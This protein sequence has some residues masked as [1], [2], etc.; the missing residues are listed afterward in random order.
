MNVTPLRPIP[1]N[2][3]PALRAAL[4]QMRENLETGDGVRGEPLRRRITLG[5][6]VSLGMVDVVGR[7]VGT[8]LTGPLDP[9]AIVPSG[10][11]KPNLAT[12]P[13][14]ENLVATAGFSKILLE[15]DEPAYSN[16]GLTEVYRA[17]TD[18]LSD[19]VPLGTS[20]FTLYADSVE[21]GETWFYW[22]RFV[23][24]TDVAGPYNDDAG[25]EATTAADPAA[26]LAAL[27]GVI[28]AS[29]LH[30]DLTS[31]IN[32][33]D[34]SEALAGSVAARIKQESTERLTADESFTQQLL[35]LSSAIAGNAAA[36]TQ[37][38]TARSD[39]D[40]ATASQINQLSTTVNGHTASIEQHTQ[41]IDGIS[42]QWT[43]KANVNG[44][45]SGVG[46]MDDGTTSIFEILANHFAVLDPLNPN[47]VIL[48][49]YNGAAIIDG[50]YIKTAT[51]QSAAIGSL[52][53]DKLI[54]DTASF[55]IA[56]IGDAT[57]GSAQLAN[58]IQSTNYSSSAGWKIYKSGTAYFNQAVIRG[59]IQSAGYS[60]NTSGWK[61]WSSG[62]F[63]LRGPDGVILMTSSGVPYSAVTG[64]PPT[65]ADRTADNTSAN[66][67][68]VAGTSA[69]TV[70]DNASNGA[71]F[72]S[73][74]AGSLAYLNHVTG[75]YIANLTVDTLHIKNHAV[76]VPSTAGGSSSATAYINAQG[77][78]VIGVGYMAVTLSHVG[79]DVEVSGEVKVKLQFGSHGSNYASQPYRFDAGGGKTLYFTV[80]GAVAAASGN[81]PL[82]VSYEN[83]GQ[84]S[85]S[86]SV[87]S[88]AAVG[89]KK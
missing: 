25:T 66:T 54:G 23:S 77:G 80:A 82:T 3:D 68:A 53:V 32:L 41:S 34:G 35:Q 47:K 72:T 57:I 28:T 36:I 38:S 60:S 78:S 15:W 4:E 44:R 5:D 59:T 71:S 17:P 13:R 48:G 55:V 20:T 1:A 75:T 70:R 14:P 86:S 69:S 11:G 73:S 64:G 85:V 61:L 52:S 8:Q 19:A 84:A 50:A 79:G 49:T 67:N 56:N 27:E 89:A 42:A 22:I 63:T 65:N 29:Q 46:L 51:I 76:T 33:I 58:S 39:G 30:A 2:I 40:S 7:L 87:C 88:V 74:D 81:T 37:E 45:V 43:I 18:N 21:P 24:D 26:M 6:L 31:R 12:P 83:I 9:N 10:G 16:H 62:A